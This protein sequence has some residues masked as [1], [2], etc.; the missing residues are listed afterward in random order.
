[1]KILL[2]DDD[3]RFRRLAASALQEASIEHQAVTKAH[4]ALRALARGRHHSFDLCVFDQELP[5]M[6]GSELLAS[7]RRRGILTPVVVTSLCEAVSEKIKA[8]D[9][10]ADDYLVKPFEFGELLARI[11]AVLRRIRTA[12]VLRTGNVELDPMLRRARKCG[13]PME[14]TAR[15]FDVLWLL[16]QARGRAVSRSEFLHQ[17]WDLDFEPHTNSLEVYISRLRRKL[18]ANGAIHIE[19]V[20]GKG[21]RVVAAVSSLLVMSETAYG[22]NIA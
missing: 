14:L 5:G 6:R 2:V 3:P 21:Y 8:L 17:A 10:G 15:E 22:G 1:M 7:L 4:D 9:L 12:E 18:D 11:R 16:M 19:T 13:K 20:R